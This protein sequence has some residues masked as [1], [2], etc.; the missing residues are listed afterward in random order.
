MLKP[1]MNLSRPAKARNMLRRGT[2]QI[3]PKAKAA[4]EATKTPIAKTAQ[5]PNL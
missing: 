4:R 5:S 3:V 1:S 2:K